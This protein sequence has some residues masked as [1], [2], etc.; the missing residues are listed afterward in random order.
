MRLFYTKHTFHSRTFGWYSAQL[1]KVV[2]STAQLR[3]YNE[4]PF[5][6]LIGDT[7]AFSNMIIDGYDHILD[8]VDSDDN[9]VVEIAKERRHSDLSKLLE[10]IQ[11]FEVSAFNCLNN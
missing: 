2:I 6:Y 11:T 10:T 1:C 8:I 4:K 5:N 3:S 7:E 9:T